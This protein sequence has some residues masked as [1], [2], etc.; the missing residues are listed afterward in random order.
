MV[1]K[2]NERRYNEWKSGKLAEK[3]KSPLP[4]PAIVKL[5]QEDAGSREGSVFS[6]HDSQR[7]TPPSFVGDTPAPP[8]TSS[9]PVPPPASN[10]PVLFK[11]V[12]RTEAEFNE[13][14]LKR[15]KLSGDDLKPGQE[16]AMM[17]AYDAYLV[18]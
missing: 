4:N 2:E 18:L 14:W 7:S 6:D 16:A 15:N 9:K 17:D 8:A 5:K 1:G 13:S 11:K 12:K 10:I 3:D